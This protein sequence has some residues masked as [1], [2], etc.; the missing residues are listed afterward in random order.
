MGVWE[1]G[2][3]KSINEEQYTIYGS[4]TCSISRHPYYPDQPLLN[5]KTK[6]LFLLKA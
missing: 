1:C 4:L 6:S 5:Q 2:S 3:M